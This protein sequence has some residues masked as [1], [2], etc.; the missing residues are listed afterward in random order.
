[1]SK[2]AL[3]SF[4]GTKNINT[5][6]QLTGSKSE[7]N[8]ALIISALSKK[9][10]K[11][12]N[13]SN[14]ADTVTLNGILNNLEEELEVEIQESKTVDVGPA[15]TAMRFLSAYLSAKNGNFLLTGTERMKQRPI[16]ILAEALK[17]IGAD[18]SY[19]ESEG[20]PPLS[21]VGP[22]NQKTA[23]VKIKG[24]VS[25]QYISAL[26]MIAPILPKGLTLEIEGD[27]IIAEYDFN[28]EGARSIREIVFLKKDGK[29]YEGFGDVETKG[30][31]VVFKNRAALKFDG[32][33][34][35]DPTACK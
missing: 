3:V 30:T 24:D 23:E 9:L 27:T 33:L 21:I 2:N 15:G 31:K 12:E 8:R 7:C 34:V 19:A 13:L 5:E 26:L 32:G 29:L 14:A 22:L 4:K 35:F 20:F 16:G 1:M 17:T 18:I 28:S 25:S 6:I 11:V 10:V